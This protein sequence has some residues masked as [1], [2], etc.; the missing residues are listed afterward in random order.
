MFRAQSTTRNEGDLTSGCVAWIDFI[1]TALRRKGSVG[2]KHAKI[3]Q[4]WDWGGVWK[5]RSMPAELWA[6][7]WTHRQ[8]K[9]SKY[10]QIKDETHKIHLLRNTSLCSHSYTWKNYK[11]KMYTSCL[12]LFPPLPRPCPYQHKCPAYPDI[13]LCGFGFEILLFLNYACKYLCSY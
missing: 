6:W 13:I 4:M 7:C 11:C 8:T 2:R 1:G 12:Y 5:L 9:S 3:F 10:I